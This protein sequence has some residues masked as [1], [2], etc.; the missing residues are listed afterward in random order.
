MVDGSIW[1]GISYTMAGFL[2]PWFVAG[3]WAGGESLD[4]YFVL[5]LPIHVL[6]FSCA[7]SLLR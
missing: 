7:K 5:L 3:P 1:Y 2:V 4:L 6:G